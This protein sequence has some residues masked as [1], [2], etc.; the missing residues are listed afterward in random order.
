MAGEAYRSDADYLAALRSA[1]LDSANT[2]ADVRTRQDRS[3]R[4]LTDLLPELAR[5]GGFQ[6]EGINTGFESRGLY[7]SGMRQ[8]GIARQQY[9][10]AKT[11]ADYRQRSAEEVGDLE[12]QLARSRA[13]STRRITDAGY[14]AQQRG[15]ARTQEESLRREQQSRED[16]LAAQLRQMQQATYASI[17]R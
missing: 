4:T 5:Q 10:E 16:A 9:D 6:R 3:R 8:D 14:S 11:G 17:Y 1:N 13:D 15:Y 12:G 2:E 7:R